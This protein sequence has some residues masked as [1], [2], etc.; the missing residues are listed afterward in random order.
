[1]MGKT[2]IEING[3]LAEMGH[4]QDIAKGMYAYTDPSTGSTA[5]LEKKRFLIAS[6]RM[7]A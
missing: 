6:G 2:K 1:M 4:L 3:K 5:I 7:E